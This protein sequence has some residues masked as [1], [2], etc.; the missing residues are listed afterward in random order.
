RLG[1]WLS[2]P[3]QS[4][5]RDMR[6]REAIGAC[7]AAALLGGCGLNV[8]SPDLFQLT[9]TGQ[10]SELV[11]L[12]NDSGTVRCNGGKARALSDPLLLQA[13]ALVTSL[14][15]DAKARLNVPGTAVSA[16]SYSVRFQAGT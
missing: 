14:D 16:Y 15:N 2:R 4:R 7:V 3:D 1:A 6:T 10:G 9:R 5:S 12:V 13:R 8:T 11:V